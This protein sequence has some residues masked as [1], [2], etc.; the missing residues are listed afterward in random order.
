MMSHDRPRV[1]IVEDQYFVAA[2]CEL[3]LTAAGIECV[4]LATTADEAVRLAGQEA[5]DLVVMDIRLAGPVD[6]IAAAIEIHERFAIRSLF[7]SAHVRDNMYQHAQHACPLGW[8]EKPYS[9]ENL[10]QA[11]RHALD[12]LGP[13]AQR[14]AQAGEDAV[15]RI[16]PPSPGRQ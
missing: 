6:G 16:D 7:V 1:L 10:V 9:A 2:D 4:G 3:N 12:T 5:P 15:T 11:V 14:S 8:L 13:R